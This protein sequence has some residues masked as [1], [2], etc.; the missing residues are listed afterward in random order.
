MNTKPSKYGV[1]ARTAEYRH[2][3]YEDHK[4]KLREYQR[5]YY[6]DHLEEK[7]EY[8]RQQ[9]RIEKLRAIIGA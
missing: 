2:R 5:Q 4:E 6:L 8:A 7:R 3:Y 1:K 9:Y